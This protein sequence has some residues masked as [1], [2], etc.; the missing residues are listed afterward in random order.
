MRSRRAQ[1]KKLLFLEEYKYKVIVIVLPY[2]N[3][4]PAIEQC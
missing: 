4:C 3:F 2:F 1:E